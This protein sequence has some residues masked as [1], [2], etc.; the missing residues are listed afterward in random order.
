MKL[1][2]NNFCIINYSESLEELIDKTV[3]VLNKKIKEYENIFNIN[4]KDKIVIN[5]FDKL[6]EFREFIYD[7]RG[8]RNSLPEYAKGTYDN[9]MINAYIDI[10]LLDKKIYNASHELFHILYLKQIL[11][12]D[13][14]NRIV[15]YDE[16]MAQFISGEKDYLNDEKEFIKYYK[17]LK[18]KNKIIPNLN[19]LYHGTSFMNDN[20]NGYQLSYLS[21]RYLYEI[22]SEEEFYSL[23][24]DI[25]KVKEI[26]CDI[27]EKAIKYFNDRL[28]RLV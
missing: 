26:G 22:L 1:F 25:D 28:K 16:G 10:N 4:I 20:Y 13:L 24:F 3:E 21:I 8:E 7:I 2:Q 15:W 6:E 18:E 17:E 19:E 12:G 23:L 11:N 27:A 14:R 5:Y 9:G